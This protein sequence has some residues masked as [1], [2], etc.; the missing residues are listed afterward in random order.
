MPLVGIGIPPPP[1]PHPQA[2]VPPPPCFWGEGNTRWRERGWESP[3]SDEG[4]TLWYSLYVRTLWMYPTSRKRKDAAAL[5]LSSLS[6][7]NITTGFFR[8]HSSRN[9]EKFFVPFHWPP[10]IMKEG[11]WGELQMLSFRI[12]WSDSE[13]SANKWTS[14]RTI[15]NVIC[16]LGVFSFCFPDKKNI[17]LCFTWPQLLFFFKLVLQHMKHFFIW[18]N[19]KSPNRVLNRSKNRSNRNSLLGPGIDTGKIFSLKIKR[20]TAKLLMLTIA[21][22]SICFL[23]VILPLSLC[24]LSSGPVKLKDIHKYLLSQGC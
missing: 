6:I 12:H 4:H 15:R 21:F 2:S 13:T 5:F 16:Y 20:T 10:V 22:C 3:N 14:S 24:T 17:F 18:K 7:L 9:S 11:G 23:F 1:T 19:F 8:R